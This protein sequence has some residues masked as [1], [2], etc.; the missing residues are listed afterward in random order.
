MLDNQIDISLITESWLKSQK[1]YITFLLKESGFNISHFNRNS[2]TGGGVAIISSYK[3]VSKFQKSGQYTSFEVSIQTFGIK[4]SSGLTFIVIYRHHAENVSV[5]FDEFHTFLEYV[6]LKFKKFIIAGD[7]NIH[8]NKQHEKSTIEFLD[9][10]NTF[11][12]VQSISTSTHK[13][14]NTLDLILHNPELVNVNNIDVDSTV[15]DGRDHYLI[16]F[17]VQ[18]NLICETKQEITYRNYKDLDIPS[19]HDN[20]SKSNQL[21]LQQ[22]KG[23]NF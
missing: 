21:F 15:R 19:F 10:L 11:S 9:I 14:G 17:N 2:K 3:Y 6:N 13:S 12:L 16:S 22:S 7:F 5:F 8:V 1:N 18:C 4:D 20:I 23:A